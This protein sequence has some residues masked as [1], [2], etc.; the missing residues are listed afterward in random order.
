[1]LSIFFI[2]IVA[3][4][5]AQRVLSLEEAIATALHNNYDIQL[6][7][8][9]SMVAAIDYSYR[10]AIFLPSVN[11]TASTTKNNNRQKQIL[12]DD[13]ERSGKVKNQNIQGGMGLN[14]VLFDGFKMFATRD[15]AAALLQ[16]GIY[17][18]KEQIVNTI[19]IV[20]NTYYNIARQQQMIKA[21]DMQIKLNEERAKLAQY[22]LDIGTGAKPDV[23]QS[24]VDLNSQRALRMQQLNHM[25]Q[26]KQELVQVMNSNIQ[27]QE[28]EVPDTIPV[29]YDMSIGNLQD[30]IDFSN[31]S[32]L[33][34][35]SRIDIAAYSLKESLAS[36]WP[37]ISFN[38]A[39]NFMRNKNEIAIS[40]FSTKLN[41]SAGVSYGLGMQVPIFNQFRLRRQIQQDRL[42]LN[43]SKLNYDNRRSVILLNLMN[44]FRNYDQQK[45][46]L[47][48]EEENILLAQENV[49]ILY[50]SYQLGHATL[51]QLREA[52]L[53]LA[54]ANDRLIAARYQIKLAETELMRLR[55]DIVK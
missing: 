28:F 49:N 5:Q 39:Y 34:A 32:L 26:L 43:M 55:G 44:T 17:A 50:Q 7:K 3:Q 42:S 11:A 37:T 20:I 53:S 41:Q 12:A 9:D 18:A 25:Q 52:Q 38:S 27:P 4:S 14:W 46:Q 1:M 40:P 36:R 15:K 10:Q 45:Q 19:A 29:N 48:L 33:L 2:L 13:S 35:K 23:L 21:T 22:R 54:Q 47:K 31:P 6:A 8:N 51:M 16:A 30:G 24:K